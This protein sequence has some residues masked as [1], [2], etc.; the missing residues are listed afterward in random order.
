MTPSVRLVQP[1]ALAPAV[2][3]AYAA[4]APANSRLVFLAGVCPLD[5]DGRTVA[6][7]DLVG[8]ARICVENM[9]VAL[10]ACGAELTDVVFVRVLVASSSR[11]D[12]A[13]VWEVVH[14]A[15]GSYEPPG[16]LQGVTVLGWQ[17]QLVEVEVVA[18]VADE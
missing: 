17:D 3:Y 10:D 15:F 7:G 9:K 2:P 6:A 8:Q 1:P 5:P 12:L 18:A 11:A 13:A 4:V 14:E 16:T